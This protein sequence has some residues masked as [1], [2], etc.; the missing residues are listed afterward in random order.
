MKDN[1]IVR[2]NQINKQSGVVSIFIVIFSALLVTIVTVSFVSLMIRNQQQAT[3]ADLSNSAYDAAMAGVEDAKRL[4]L[5]YRTCQNDPSKLA[6]DVCNFAKA[7]MEDLDTTGQ[8][9]CN[10]VRRGLF[11]SD[12]DKEV[13]VQQTKSGD[14]ASTS[15][16][17]AYTCVKIKYDTDSLPGSIKQDETDIIPLDTGGAPFD[18]VTVSWFLKK[19]DE[20]K[21]LGFY[22]GNPLSLPPKGDW[23]PSNVTTQVVAPIMRTQF[24]QVGDNFSLKD[25]DE[26]RAD[27]SNTNTLFL[28]PTNGVGSTEVDFQANDTRPA[29]TAKSPQV[30]SCN[31]DSYRDGTYACSATIKV[32]AQVG[33]EARKLAYLRL[34]PLY[35]NTDT[36]YQVQVH[37]GPVSPTST[38]PLVGVAPRV[39]S[40]G[41]AN[42]L[43]RRVQ[44]TVRFD[45]DFSYPKGT[46]D[47][48]G[49][50]CKNF[51]VTDK[52]GDYQANCTP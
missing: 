23:K 51:R 49:N 14:L 40:T 44:A 17:Q 3:D 16:N 27:G 26:D 21:A 11:R 39:D 7:S 41:R 22:N 48:N 35:A 29:I 18:R 32:G 47:V 33:G 10:S 9:Q 34:S 25:F 46:I 12:D 43:F 42:V 6:T 2:S 30:V 52:L 4:M 31:P 8:T 45:S 19:P 13:L 15:L 5:I 38:V 20:S 24:M 1:N 50:L 37:S 36:E 28:Y